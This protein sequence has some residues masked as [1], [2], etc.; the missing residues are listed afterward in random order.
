[1]NNNLINH[2]RL[3][4]EEGKPESFLNIYMST[5]KF[6]KMSLLMST[7][8]QN[9]DEETK[10]ISEEILKE[11]NADMEIIIREFHF[12]LM[13]RYVKML[14]NLESSTNKN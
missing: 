9:E 11:E 13:K 5:T 8:R 2:R 6:S 10:N 4:T 12:L 14:Y 3:K 1:M 7:L